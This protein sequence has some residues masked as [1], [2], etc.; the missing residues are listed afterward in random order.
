MCISIY[1]ALLHCCTM[2]ESANLFVFVLL[3]A[4]LELP[5][6]LLCLPLDGRDLCFQVSPLVNECHQPTNHTA[7]G[8]T[9]GR[10]YVHVT[11]Y[12][13]TACVH[14]QLD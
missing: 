13:L 8:M 9:M 10:L 4:S 7:T 2:I 11:M 5:V 1:S 14:T 6:G 12:L 3:H